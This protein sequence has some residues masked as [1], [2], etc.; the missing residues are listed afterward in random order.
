MIGPG[1]EAFGMRT[2]TPMIDLILLPHEYGLFEEGL[3]RYAFVPS[4][5]FRCVHLRMQ[6]QGLGSYAGDAGDW[7]GCLTISL[8]NPNAPF[9][10]VE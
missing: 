3:V 10:P 6:L 9:R 2:H 8:S 4:H 5:R 1:E 7:Q